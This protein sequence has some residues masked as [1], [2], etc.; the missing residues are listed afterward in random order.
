MGNHFGSQIA[1]IC[2]EVVLAKNTKVNFHETLNI[3]GA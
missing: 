3:F 2:T 1:Q